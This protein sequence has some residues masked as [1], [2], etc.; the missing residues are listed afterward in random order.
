MFTPRNGFMVAASTGSPQVNPSRWERDQGAIPSSNAAAMI[1]AALS[2][3]HEPSPR[4][5]V[6]TNKG[7][8][9][10]WSSDEEIGRVRS[11]GEPSFRADI[12]RDS[13][14]RRDG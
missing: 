9:C 6:A 1:P 8:S 7:A 4:R 10:H 5:G 2:H 13:I 3:G 11:E 14:R 12:G